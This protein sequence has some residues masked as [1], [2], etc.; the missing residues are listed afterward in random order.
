M[1]PCSKVDLLKS[2]EKHLSYGEMY[3]KWYGCIAADVLDCGTFTDRH[4]VLLLG[5]SKL[6]LVDLRVLIVF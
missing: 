5:G 6:Y 3:N 2:T 4:D 1:Q